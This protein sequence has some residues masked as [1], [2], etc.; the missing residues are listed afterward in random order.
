MTKKLQEKQPL[1]QDPNS[2]NKEAAESA[3]V[4]DQ[5]LATKERNQQK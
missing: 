1:L 4:D 5:T 3:E 2:C